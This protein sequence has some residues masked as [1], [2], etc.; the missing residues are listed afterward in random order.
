MQT[1]T[2]N[3]TQS[4]TMPKATQLPDTLFFVVGFNKIGKEVVVHRESVE[5][6][7]IAAQFFDEFHE[8]SMPASLV[9]SATLQKR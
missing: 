6:A 7:K 9:Y 3:T 1:K 5:E 4:R 2:P 8:G